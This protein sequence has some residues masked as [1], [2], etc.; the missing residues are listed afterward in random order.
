MGF[1]PFPPLEKGA[2]RPG[3]L[4]MLIAFRTRRERAGKSQNVAPLLNKLR[5]AVERMIGCKCASDRRHDATYID[6]SHRD[7]GDPVNLTLRIS[8]SL[9]NIAHFDDLGREP[10]C[11]PV[12][13]SSCI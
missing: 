4:S 13:S 7:A 6:S 9:V 10:G 2:K 8:G 1:Q 3:N 11:L 12:Y 5:L